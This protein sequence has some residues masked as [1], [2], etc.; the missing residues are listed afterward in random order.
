MELRQLQQF[1]AVADA[2]SFRLAA[3]RL[4]MA[5]PPLSVAIRKLEEEIGVLLFERGARGVRLTAPGVLAL[6][7]AQKCLRDAEGV[8]SSARAADKGEAGVLRISFIGSVTFGLMPRIV[9][10]FH[11]RYPNV[12][13]ELHEATNREALIAVDSGTADLGFVRIPALCP[14]GVALQVMEKDIFCVALP[15]SH[16]LTRR[17][18][19]RLSDLCDKPFVGYLPSQPGGGLHAAVMQLFIKAGLTPTVTQEAV[20]VH[21]V[22]GLVESGL[23]LALVPSVHALHASNRVAFRPLRGVPMKS[24]IGV[25][26]AYRPKD[27]TA[28]ARRFRALASERPREPA[29][30]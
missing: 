10:S 2:K 29:Q 6:E 18:T 25:A 27:E 14:P 28:V 5:Q 9:G 24:S 13:L 22:I 7:A 1:V 11:D 21:T 15:A 3:E 20:Q 12:R 17:R 23:G 26:L 8:V 19:L 16:P 4:F 30:P